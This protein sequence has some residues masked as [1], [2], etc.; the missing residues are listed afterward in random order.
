MLLFALPSQPNINR[1]AVCRQRLWVQIGLFAKRGFVA[2]RDHRGVDDEKDNKEPQPGVRRQSFW[3]HWLRKLRESLAHPV[4]LIMQRA[5]GDAS[6]A[7]RVS[8]V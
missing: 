1:L 7:L 4:A 6:V 8:F 2:D 5:G 3:N